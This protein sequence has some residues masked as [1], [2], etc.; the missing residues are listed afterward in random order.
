[1]ESQIVE[2]DLYN[3]KD[4]VGGIIGV[5]KIGENIFRAVEN[6]LFDCR[7][8]LGVEFETK[9]NEEGKHEIVK[10]T[11]PSN[12]ITRRFFLS[13]THTEP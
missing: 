3:R 7:L 1:M 4:K 12:Y 9:I 8:T 11:K 2:I 10:I 13:S 5:E 6:E